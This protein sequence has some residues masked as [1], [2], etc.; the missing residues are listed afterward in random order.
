ML[1]MRPQG[2][3]PEK[4]SRTLNFEEVFEDILED[5]VEDEQAKKMIRE[6]RATP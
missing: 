5:K 1:Y 3:I 2:I 4:P 6:G